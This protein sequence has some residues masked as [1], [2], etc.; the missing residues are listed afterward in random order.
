MAEPILIGVPWRAALRRVPFRLVVGA[1]LLAI[2]LLLVTA[3]RHAQSA[4]PA[5][6]EAA[7]TP[8]SGDDM[9]L[10]D[11]DDDDP[12]YCFGPVGQVANLLAADGTVPPTQSDADL[13]GLAATGLMLMSVGGAAVVSGTAGGLAGLM[14]SAGGAGVGGAGAGGAGV[15]GTAG[16]AGVGG[17]GMA[18]AGSAGATGTAAG[19]GAVHAGAAAHVVS[20]GQG[21]AGA[22]GMAGI[23]GGA[24]LIPVASPGSLISG[25]AGVASNLPLPRAELVEAGLSI[26]RSMKRITS[27]ADPSGYSAGDLAE[28]IGDATSIGA[29]AS[30]LAPAASLVSL[31][32]AGAAAGAETADPKDVLEK[33]RRSFGQLGYMQGVLDANIDRTDGK[34][35]GLDGAPEGAAT[36][37]APAI[38]ADLTRLSDRQLREARAAWAARAD[39]EFDALIEAQ[40][41]LGDMDDRRRNLG[42]QID[43]VNDLLSNLDAAGSTPVPTHLGDTLRYGLGWHKAANPDRMASALRDSRAKAR[44]G[45]K[46]PRSAPASSTVTSSPAAPSAT[47]SSPAPSLA[48]GVPFAQWAPSN[49]FGTGLEEARMAVLEALAGLERWS[50]FF[51]ALTG[52][53]QAQVATLRSQADTATANRRALS[54]EI[55]RRT[56][57][58]GKR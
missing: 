51:D 49:G 57:E 14:G 3:T 13:G 1:V 21:A 54:A 24:G 29:L 22:A 9:S 46:P 44:A 33:L 27:E 43:E 17:A 52:T 40:D 5:A 39:V 6:P 37:A 50:G 56:L 38:P 16:G 53:L 11:D 48:P 7:Q 26:F 42:H 41:D 55:Q 10:C 20:A 35:T 4:S 23:G 30:I 47:A 2:G 18:G 31:A 58:G 12:L 32:T 15:G 19:S 8:Q 28:F 45:G 25:V 34:L 36:K